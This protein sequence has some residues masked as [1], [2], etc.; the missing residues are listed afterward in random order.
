MES[1]EETSVHLRN[2]VA[3]NEDGELMVCC[4]TQVY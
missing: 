4:M 2:K 3:A 1:L